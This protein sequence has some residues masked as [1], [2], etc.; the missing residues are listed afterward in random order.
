DISTVLH[1]NKSIVSKDMAHLRQQARENLQHHFHEVVPMEYERC[2]T[3][4]KG[5]LKHVL[6]I[7][8]SASDPKT[9]LQARAIVNDRYKYIMDL[10]TNG[11]IVNDAIKYVQ[12]NMDHLNAAEKKVLQDIQKADSLEEE[13]SNS[14]EGKNTNGVF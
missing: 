13:E 6:E 1:V 4:M 11:V 3:G 5:N 7:A 12:S 2:M 9:K 14:A 10:T 8:E